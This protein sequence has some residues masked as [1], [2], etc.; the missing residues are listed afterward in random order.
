MDFKNKVKSDVLQSLIDLMEEKENEGLKSKSPKF[1]KVDIMSDDPE[2]ANELKNKL[3]GKPEE[4]EAEAETE[5][6]FPSKLNEEKFPFKEEEEKPADPEE[7]EDMKR[8]L[9]M[10]KDLKG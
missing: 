7:D 8:L 3:V 1:A 4:E 5:A 10:Y 2:L 9:E 6:K